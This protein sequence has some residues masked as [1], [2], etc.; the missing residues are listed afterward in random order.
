VQLAIYDKNCVQL[1]EVVSLG[2]PGYEGM[3][4]P[5]RS[6]GTFLFR[7]LWDQS[8]FGGLKAEHKKDKTLD[9]QPAFC[10]V[11]WSLQHT[12]AGS[13]IEMRTLFGYK[14]TIIVL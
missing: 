14:G 10:N 6:Q 13:R 1:T 5:I 7:S 4:S 8:L 2:M 12:K 11:A 9:G 3:K